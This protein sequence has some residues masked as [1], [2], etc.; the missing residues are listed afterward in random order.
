MKN[1]IIFYTKHNFKFDLYSL[2]FKMIENVMII[3]IIGTVDLKIFSFFIKLFI[4]NNLNIY[5][6][7][8]L[9]QQTKN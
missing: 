7:I 3:I 4:V 8:Y 6:F 9:L 1:K 2:N 5:L